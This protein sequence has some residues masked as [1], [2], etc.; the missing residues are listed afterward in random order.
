[1]PVTAIKYRTSMHVELDDM[2]RTHGI[3]SV[4]ATIA[5]I[6]EHRAEAM[7]CYT[8]GNAVAERWARLA[9]HVDIVA[10]RAAKL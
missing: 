1:M 10:G 3:R 4:L 9:V 2:I 8:P 5:G 6:C 7:D